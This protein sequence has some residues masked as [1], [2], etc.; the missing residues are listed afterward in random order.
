MTRITL[1]QIAKAV[2]PPARAVDFGAGTGR[3][4]IPLSQA[5]YQ[6]TA[7]DPVR[8]ML[9][10]LEAGAKAQ[11]LE[12]ETFQGRMMDFR[13][14]TAYDLA[15]C[16][17]TVL[18]YILD[19]ES[20]ERSSQAVA[21]SLKP[22]GMFLVDV[23]RM[24]MFTGGVVRGEGVKRVMDI[25]PRGGDLY[26]YVENTSVEV[27]GRTEKFAEAFTIRYW[28]KDLV[29]EHLAQA[30]FVMEKDLSPLLRRS[31]CDYYLMRTTS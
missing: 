23:P 16:V 8:G 10:V 28:P 26:D 3:L 5:G 13:A 21:E 11:G 25:T 18:L 4:A 31:G 12:M 20:L 29:L 30:G 19:E 6:V 7:V 17:F 15:I 22:G 1:E 9:D 2:P 27:E 24:E 14:E